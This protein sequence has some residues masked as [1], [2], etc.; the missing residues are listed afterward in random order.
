MRTGRDWSDVATSQGIPEGIR[1]QKQQG[2]DSP[3][4]PSEGAQPSSHLDLG[5]LASRTVREEI[6]VVLRHLVFDNLLL[7]R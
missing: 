6:S 2:T 3:L 4:E 7:Q 5:P 1:G